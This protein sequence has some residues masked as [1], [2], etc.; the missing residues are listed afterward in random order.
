MR[1]IKITAFENGAHD[2]QTY[3]GILPEGYAFLPDELECENFPFGNVTVEEKDG[4]PVVTAWE[5]LPIPVEPEPEVEETEV[6][7][8]DMANA[9]LEGVNEV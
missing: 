6:S 3:H 2:N 7:T 5:P 1:I 9:I 8:D 4:I